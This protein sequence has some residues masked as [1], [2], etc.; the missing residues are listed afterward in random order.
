MGTCTTCGEHYDYR[1]QERINPDGTRECR[2]DGDCIGKVK[3]VDLIA[4]GK[5][6][7][8]MSLDRKRYAKDMLQPYKHD[9]SVNE[10]FKKVYGPNNE[11]Y[12]QKTKAPDP[13]M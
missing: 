3:E 6:S 1:C 2:H 12:K 8:R 4:G 7:R 13:G 5:W 11:A 9:G 10:N